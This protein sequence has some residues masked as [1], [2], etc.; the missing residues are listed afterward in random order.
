MRWWDSHW[1][2]SLGSERRKACLK[3]W[4]LSWDLKKMKTSESRKGLW[5]Y[6]PGWELPI[7]YLLPQG[8]WMTIKVFHE[9]MNEP[10][11]VG[12]DWTSV[13]KL[14]TASPHMKY[15]HQPKSG[16]SQVLI[17]VGRKECHWARPGDTQVQR[18]SCGLPCSGVCVLE[19]CYPMQTLTSRARSSL[20][21]LSL[22]CH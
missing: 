2:S 10:D 4:Y 13:I 21:P 11:Y 19:S 7:I 6:F 18:V 20:A 9:W 22:T 1:Q 3:S 17:A 8:Q 15:S 14:S 16:P 12:S 5:Q